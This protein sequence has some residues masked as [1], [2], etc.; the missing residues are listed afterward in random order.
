[1]DFFIPSLKQGRWKD[2][3]AHLGTSVGVVKIQLFPE[4]VIPNPLPATIT[5]SGGIEV[6]L[7]GGMCLQ[8]LVPLVR[9]EVGYRVSSL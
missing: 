9:G 3:N 8:P 4:L 5:A 7:C 2:F 1:M 6:S